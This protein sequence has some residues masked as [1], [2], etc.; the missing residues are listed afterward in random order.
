MYTLAVPSRG[1]N[2]SKINLMEAIPMCFHYKL[3]I[4]IT[5]KGFRQSHLVYYFIIIIVVTCFDPVESS[6]GLHNE[7]ANY[8]ALY[9]LGISNIVY[10]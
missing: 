10:K 6:S 2:V 1:R 5:I 7:L 8:K 9:I 4:I 3:I